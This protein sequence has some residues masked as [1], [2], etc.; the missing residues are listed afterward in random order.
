MLEKI[1]ENKI[2]EMKD[3]GISEKYIAELVK[4]RIEIQLNN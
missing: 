3:L 1:K 4:K 2:K